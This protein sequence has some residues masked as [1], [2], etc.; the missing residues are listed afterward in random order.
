MS[1]DQAAIDL[2]SQASAEHEHESRR[3][4]L[5]YADRSCSRLQ[6]R[7]CPR[8]NIMVDIGIHFS[9][10]LRE[11]VSYD[12]IIFVSVFFVAHFHED[13]DYFLLALQFV[14]RR[15]GKNEYETWL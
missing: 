7:P 14:W 15:M 10:T 6:Y 11:I 12:H 13:C 5:R 8:Y 1:V 3:P 4:S 9:S 2:N